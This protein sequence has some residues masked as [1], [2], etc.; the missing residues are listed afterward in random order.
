M[1]DTLPLAGKVALVTGASRGIGRAIALRLAADGARVGVNYQRN[2]AAAEATADAIGAAGGNA[3][4]LPADIAERS[5]VEAMVAALVKSWGRLDILV[6]NAGITRDTLL[7]RLGEDDWDAVLNTNLRGAYLCAKASIR[8]MLRGG[9][10][11]INVSSVVGQTGNA[12]QTNYAAAKAGLIGFTM[13][14]A[15]EVASRKITVNAVAPGYITTDMTAQMKPEHT[16]RLLQMIPLARLGMPEE[17][18][19]LVA[20]LVS[21][22]A[23][24]I[25]GQ[26]IRVDGGMVMA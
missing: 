18:A 3:L 21:E 20:F 16:E 25:T 12:G 26:T 10:R 7:L 14:L 22:Q 23:A 2:A 11:I 24:Y 9:G 5:A 15:R 19:D 6:N 4:L 1:S 13:A 8:H 17:V